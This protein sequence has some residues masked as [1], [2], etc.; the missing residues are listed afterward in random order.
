ME[1]LE[2]LRKSVDAT[3]DMQSI[4]R[5]MKALAAVSIRQYER[6]L[7]SLSDYDGAIALGLQVVLEHTKESAPRR[8]REQS[9][10]VGAIVFGSDQG[11]CG[12]FN[13]QVTDFALRA[14]EKFRAAPDSQRLLAVGSRAQFS[15]EQR[16]QHVQAGVQVPGSAA[17]IAGCV[18]SILLVVEEWR[19]RADI[20]DVVLFYN[21]HRGDAARG[22]ASLHLLPVNTER[23]RD[24]RRADW[25]SRSL[26][27][28]SMAQPALLAALV[29]Q[30]LFVSVFRA[31]AQSLASEHASRLESMQLAEKN[32]ENHLGELEAAYRQRRQEEITVELLDVVAGYEALTSAT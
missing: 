5:T 13:D 17:G 2:S 24:R 12:R 21:A 22:P 15:L 6:A 4:V 20:T 8:R 18:R 27:T 32:I 7:A 14:M 9:R 16:G 19:A 28:Y 26:P 25:P 29:R 31:C 30:Y 3:R 10:H 23:I 11:L 1:T